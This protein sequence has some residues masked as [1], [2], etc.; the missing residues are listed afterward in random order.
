MHYIQVP[1]KH[2]A[3][4]FYDLMLN[5]P[6]KCLPDNVYVVNEQQIKL[7]KKKGIPYNKIDPSTL[8]ST[9]PGIYKHEAV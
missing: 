8:R 6:V 2:N 5:G 3:E 9:D 7:L 4:A 1:E